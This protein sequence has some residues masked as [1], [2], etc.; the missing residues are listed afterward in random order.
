MLA[1]GKGYI[2]LFSSVFMYNKQ[3]SQHLPEMLLGSG[4]SAKYSR[5]TK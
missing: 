2:I 3:W 1:K 5:V 4:E